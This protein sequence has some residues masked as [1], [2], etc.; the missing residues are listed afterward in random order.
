MCLNRAVVFFFLLALPGTVA[1]A[2]HITLE[3]DGQPIRIIGEVLIEAVDGGLLV[4]DREGVL[5]MVQPDELKGRTADETPY[6]PFDSAEL[7]AQLLKR[8]PP[9]SRVHSTAHYLILYNTSPVYAQWCGALYERLYLAFCNYWER[10]GLKLREPASPMVAL[11]FDGKASYE[12]YARAELGDAVQAIVAYYSLTTNRIAM[13]DLTGT[14]GLRG[15]RS[16]VTSTTQINALLM[17]PEAYRMV[18]TIIHEATHQLAYNCGF[19]TRFAD[20]PLWV[21]EGLAV[22]FET[23]DLRSSRGWRNI[24]GVH[25][26]RLGHFRKYLADRPPDS[27]RTLIE[28]DTRFKDTST[29]ADAYAEAWALNY[30]LIRNHREAYIRYMQHLGTKSPMVYDTPAERLAAFTEVFGKGPDELDKD[31]LRYMRTVR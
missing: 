27:L 17:R 11:V 20:I 21:S 18:A 3:R 25:R 29:G 2:D 7:Q 31:F 14:G 13:H 28:T 23:P 1:A 8:M 30:Y 10:R 6:Q 5:W 24:G 15:A 9:G 12:Q 4:L 26:H 22:Y 19:H 16:G